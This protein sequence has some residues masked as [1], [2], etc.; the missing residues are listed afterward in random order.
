MRWQRA[1]CSPDAAAR[2]RVRFRKAPTR[3]SSTR[4]TSP[5]RSTTRGCPF[6][7]DRAGSIERRTVR[8][9]AARRGHRPRRDAKV[10]GI[11]VR[12]VHD[13]VTEDGGPV[14]DTYDWY[15]Q[16]ADETSGTSA[17]TRRS[18]RTARS[19]RRPVRGR[20]ESTAQPGV[21]VP[22][23]PAVGL[24]YRQEY[25]EG[26]AEDAAEILGLEEKVEVPHGRFDGVLMTK[27]YT[28]LQ[29]EIL[30]HKFYAR[31]VGLV[32]ALA[33]SGGSDREE[34]LEHDPLTAP[35]RVRA[36]SS[37]RSRG[38]PPTSRRRRLGS[39]RS[40]GLPMPRPRRP[41]RGRGCGRVPLRLP[42]ARHDRC[43]WA[44]LR[45]LRH[46]PAASRSRAA[47]RARGRL[48]RGDQRLG[49][50][51]RAARCARRPLRARDRGRATSSGGLLLGE[52][53]Q[54]ALEGVMV[55][56]VAK[57]A[58]VPAARVRRAPPW[59]PAIS[60]RSQPPRSPTDRKGYGSSA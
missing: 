31:G 20:P 28:P 21:L 47:R 7:P 42:A 12:V 60:A 17:R 54:G 2:I 53:R 24:T 51:D 22:A 3:S 56:A 15:A 29:P 26:E 16:D 43:R 4:P 13:L 52:L 38:R 45:E 39:R 46:R 35:A 30:E 25:Y 19:R 59:S 48:D 11:E 34:L 41:G 23:E 14:E 1:R 49:V 27:D 44:A 36:C 5:P 9:R 50:P 57:A 18:S 58:E 8:E 6:A 10:M 40:L 33:I 32:L 37:T 55:E